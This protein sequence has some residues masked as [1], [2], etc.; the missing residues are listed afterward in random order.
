M[1]EGTVGALGTYPC[2]WTWAIRLWGC[3]GSDK[4]STQ[5]SEHISENLTSLNCG[6]G[7]IWTKFARLKVYRLTLNCRIIECINSVGVTALL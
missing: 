6:N 5:S 7:Q 2:S 1:Q 3:Q 4:P